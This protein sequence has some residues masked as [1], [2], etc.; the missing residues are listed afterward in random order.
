MARLFGP[1]AL[2]L[3]LLPLLERARAE[4]RN[5]RIDVVQDALDRLC[6][7]PVSVNG[8]RLMQAV[9]AR[10][11]LALPN[12]T[13]ATQQTGT[14]WDERDI[15]LFAGLYDCIS[16][17]ARDLSKVFNPVALNPSWDADKHP[18]HPSG[19]SDG[20][21]F[22]P[23]GTDSAII[24]IAG[25]PPPWHNNPPERI[26]DPPEIPKIEPD[27]TAAKFQAIRSVVYWLGS[28]SKL[29]SK[30]IPVINR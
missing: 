1:A 11:S 6:L 14:L 29:G 16:V 20:G 28:A 7:P 8:A 25:P 18:R 24:P 2:D 3:P 12:F 9:A 10:Q 15:T 27:T 30:F 23:S 21:E 26:G 5:G 19:E 13:V 4:L 22:A 17:S